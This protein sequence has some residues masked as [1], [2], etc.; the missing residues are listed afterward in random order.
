MMVSTAFRISIRR[1][2]VEDA[3]SIVAIWQAIVAEKD[4][5]AVDRAFTLEEER[6]YIQSLSAREGIFLAETVV[7]TSEVSETS[8]VWHRYPAQV[9]GFQSLDLWARYLASMDHVGQLGTFVL[10]EWRGRGIG[11]QLADHTLAFAR[12]VGYE[13]LVIFVR[14]SNVGAQKFYAGV[15]FK[16]CGRFARQVKIAGE[17]D[18]EVLM[19]M[20]LASPPVP[21]LTS[22]KDLRS[23]EAKSVL[24]ERGDAVTK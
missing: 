12:S 11:R 22:F 18:D 7:K 15:G 23:P 13:K 5:S 16:P 10:H 6:A 3:A 24:Q 9:V 14:A 19:E 17:Y 2:T 8:E 20:F 21:P 4:Y 1:A